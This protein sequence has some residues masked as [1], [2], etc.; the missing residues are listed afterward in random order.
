MTA[1]GQSD[2]MV[3]DVEVHMKQ[4]HETEF[5]HAEKIAPSDIHRC[6][7]NVYRDQTVDVSTVRQWV[8]RFSSGDSDMKDKPC[9]GRPCTAITPRN[10]ECLDQLIHANQQITTRELCTELNI[11][12]NALEVMVATLE[13]RKVC[14]RWVPR[15]F[16][17]EH[18]WRKCIA[19]GGYYVEKQCFLAKNLLYQ[20]VLLC[21]LYLL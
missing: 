2:K 19:H 6:L 4:R 18:H 12:F 5:L 9:S 3:S 16:I 1:E 10:E 21:S 11:G 20:R 8:A 15:M 14:T 17:Q 7:L 13:Y